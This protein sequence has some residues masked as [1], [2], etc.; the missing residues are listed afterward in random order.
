MDK[1]TLL[2]I[3]TLLHDNYTITR[4][5]ASGGFGNTYLAQNAFGETVAIKEFFMSGISSRMAGNSQVSISIAENRVTFEEQRE[6]FIKEAR[7]LRKFYTAFHNPHL[8]A[9]YDLFNTNGTSYYVMEFI[10]GENLNE[11]LFRTKTPLSEK[12]VLAVLKQVLDALHIIYN[13]G[14]D[15]MLHLDLKPANLI[16]DKSGCVKLIDFGSSKQ[17][18]TGT[19]TST[20]VTYTR[21]YGPA[22]Q[23]EQ[24]VSKFGPWTDF[25]ALGATLYKLLT[26][27]AELPLPSDISDDHTPDKHLTLPFP[28]GITEKTK[29]LILWMMQPNRA[30][31]PQTIDDIRQ[32]L[33]NPGTGIPA[34]PPVEEEPISD[35]DITIIEEPGETPETPEPG[36]IELPDKKENGGE[37]GGTPPPIPTP[38]EG[39]AAELPKPSNE[40]NKENGNDIWVV[41]GFAVAVIFVFLFI[42]G[43]VKAC[44]GNNGNIY[45]VYS[46]DTDS[47]AFVDSV[48]CCDSASYAMTTDAIITLFGQ[49]CDY[50][51]WVNDSGEPDG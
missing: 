18:S 49:Q 31:R 47:A 16:L 6:K 12:N 40:P 27:K 22:E 38:E 24:N 10:D 28:T 46:D 48:V 11:Y 25:Y 30:Y 2:P 3:G 23:M 43:F 45:G 1:E 35:G 41:I 26:N 33:E 19:H 34:P 42:G 20:A 15:S 51:G 14:A 9:V 8:V 21:G 13:A 39:E 36:A 44:T 50:T 29:A 5:L 4:H 37:D 7:R 17:I 32:F